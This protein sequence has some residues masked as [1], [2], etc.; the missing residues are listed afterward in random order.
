MCRSHLNPGGVITQWVPFYESTPETVKSEI[1][2]FFDVFPGG[3][4]W[5]NDINGAGYDVVLLGSEGAPSLDI[6]GLQDRLDRPDHDA[7]AWSLKEVGFGTA[8]DLLA[9]YAGRG[10]D[11]GEWLAGA[12]INRDRSLRLQY[13]AGLGLNAWRGSEIFDGM[14]KFLKFPADFFRGSEKSITALKRALRLET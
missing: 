13:L 5:S 1:A 2:T 9:T 3:T 4:V 10:A 8:V 11:L 7:A 12:E 14:L 6:D